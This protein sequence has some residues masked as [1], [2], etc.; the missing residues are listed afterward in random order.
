MSADG[1]TECGVALHT[2]VIGDVTERRS[3]G[4]R[5]VLARLHAPYFLEHNANMIVAGRQ[6]DMLCMLG[7]Q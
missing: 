5:K 6:P 7:H 2:D 1:R 4:E 3:H